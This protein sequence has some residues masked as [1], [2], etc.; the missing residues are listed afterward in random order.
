[1]TRG[2]ADARAAA[3]GD[4]LTRALQAAE[5]AFVRELDGVTIGDLVRDR[6]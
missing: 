6:P 5:D 2:R 1:M 3:D 4:R